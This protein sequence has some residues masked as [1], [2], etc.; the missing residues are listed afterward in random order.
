ME[1]AVYVP[2]VHL[3]P[4][5]KN[6]WSLDN[7]M[8]EVLPPVYKSMADGYTEVVF[9]TNGSFKE[10]FNYS[11][12]LLPQHSTNRTVTIG[13]TIGLFG[14]RLYPYTLQPLLGIASHELINEVHHLNSVLH[15]DLVDQVTE[16]KDQYD[17]VERVCAY[18]TKKLTHTPTLIEKVIHQLMASQ[19]QAGIA[20][21]RNLT[22][23][24]ERQFERKFKS[25][26]G[27][28]PKYY[29]RI[30]RFQHT[31]KKFIAQPRMTFAELAYQCNYADQSHFIREFKEFS[32]MSV[33]DYFNLVNKSGSEE[34]KVIKGLILAKDEPYE[35]PFRHVPRDNARYAY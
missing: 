25:I 26:I 4:Y 5:V 16:A 30:V 34:A 17:R 32:G 9:A 3:R 1:Y 14:I 19:G 6:F 2:P 12:Y 21:L 23:L 13:K 10:Y 18:L 29:S 28:T 22:G 7:S 11:G 24:S 8:N 15:R 35:Q 20:E 33:T 31:R 27:F